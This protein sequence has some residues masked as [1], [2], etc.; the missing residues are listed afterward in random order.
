MVKPLVGKGPM[1]TIGDPDQA[2]DKPPANELQVPRAMQP[3]SMRFAAPDSKLT[4]SASIISK[5]SQSVIGARTGM[6]FG[7]GRPVRVRVIR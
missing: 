7:P 5:P 4:M 2:K 6:Q 3:A 1:R